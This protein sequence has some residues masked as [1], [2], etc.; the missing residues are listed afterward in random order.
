MPLR[1][2]TATT[3]LT[4]RGRGSRLDRP[5]H[6]QRHDGDARDKRPPTVAGHDHA[7][8]RCHWNQEPCMPLMA[9][10]RLVA[11]SRIERAEG[12]DGPRDRLSVQ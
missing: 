9:A 4:V 2:G 7:P 11:C 8:P 5:D 6:K 10:E 12:V 1:A 3:R